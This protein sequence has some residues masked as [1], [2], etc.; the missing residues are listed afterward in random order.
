MTFPFKCC[1]L[2]C[3]V[4]SP[5]LPSLPIVSYHYQYNYNDDFVRL[6]KYP[7]ILLELVQVVEMNTIPTTPGG[8]LNPT[9]E[10][11]A[12]TPT[13]QFNNDLYFLF[14]YEIQDEDHRHGYYNK[15]MSVWT[16]VF[17]PSSVLHRCSTTS[18][19]YIDD[20]TTTTTTTTTSVS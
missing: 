9:L 12:F 20:T 16:I 14:M 2:K 5:P 11:H 15:Y 19:P 13:L 17:V 8:I 18:Q 10:L 4:N 7:F 3:S 6:C 1:T